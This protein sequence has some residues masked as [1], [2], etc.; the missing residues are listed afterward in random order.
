[1]MP[2][3]NDATA[4]FAKAGRFLQAS[5]LLVNHG[6]LD[7][8]PGRAYY[9][10]YRATIALLVIG[11]V[12]APPN[13]RWSHGVVQNQLRR[14]AGDAPAR[15]LR[16]LYEERIV[17]DYTMANVTKARAQAAVETARMIIAQVEQR[18]ERK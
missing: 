10:A 14:L 5:E 13:G 12:G 15:R 18:P 16:S 4:R 7:A 3:A 11:G 2:S 9:A 8:A 1:M 6:H 17:A